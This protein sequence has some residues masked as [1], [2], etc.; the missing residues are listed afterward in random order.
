L[1]WLAQPL[2]GNIGLIH[3]YPRASRRA[4]KLPSANNPHPA[5]IPEKNLIPTFQ[6]EITAKMDV[7]TENLELE[8]H[9]LSR[10]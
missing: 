7:A 2:P 1:W 5:A 10:I 3:Q 4:A 9:P 6:F 8:E